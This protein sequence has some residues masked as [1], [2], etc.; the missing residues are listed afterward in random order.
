MRSAIRS[1]NASTMSVGA[2]EDGG[3]EDPL[4]G[5]D[6]TPILLPALVHAEGL[7]HLG[8]GSEPDRL[9]LLANRE[10]GQED[11]HDA[12]LAE[13]DAVIGMAGEL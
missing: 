7:E 6:Q 3:S 2:E 9:A 5:C 8:G 13:G 4:E 1:A 12:V 10:G 11:G